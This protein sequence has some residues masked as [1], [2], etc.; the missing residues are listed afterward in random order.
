MPKKSE[1]LIR[2]H[3]NWRYQSIRRIEAGNTQDYHRSLLLSISRED[4][5]V[6]LARILS[7][8]TG[9]KDV[10]EHSKSEELVCL[11]FDVFGV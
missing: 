4:R 3:L 5:D 7:L 8:I 2:H 9:L 6:V 10:V 1:L 11:N